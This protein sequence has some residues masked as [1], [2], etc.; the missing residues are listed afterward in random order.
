MIKLSAI[1]GIFAA[2]ENTADLSKFHEMQKALEPTGM[3][4]V[5]GIGEPTFP[6][7]ALSG[8]RDFVS[9][10]ANFA[11]RLPYDVYESAMK[12]DLAGCLADSKKFDPITEFTVRTSLAHGLS[13]SVFKEDDLLYFTYVAVAK[14]CM[15]ILGLGG[16]K[17]RSPDDNLT[18]S[19][20]EELR[21]ILEG[22]GLAGY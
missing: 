12:G 17:V 15:N 7:T 20:I 1:D 16:G 22:M 14:E 2:K 10:F 13:I 18:G 6:F 8:C 11:P 9:A 21:G 19:E 3:K 5:N 4:V